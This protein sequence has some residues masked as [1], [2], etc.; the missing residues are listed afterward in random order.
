MLRVLDFV[1]L[2][3]PPFLSTPLI[4]MMRVS[5]VTALFRGSYTTDF[6]FDWNCCIP[7]WMY[8]YLLGVK[9]FKLY[10]GLMCPGLSHHWQMILILVL[11]AKLVLWVFNLVQG[12]CGLCF[13]LVTHSVSYPTCG[14]SRQLLPPL[15]SSDIYCF[16]K[17]TRTPVPFLICKYCLGR[18]LWW[19]DRPSTSQKN[20]IP[21]IW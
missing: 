3:L 14:Y 15:W 5:G 12:N 19:G 1:G 21:W 8:Q 13:D 10:L 16:P 4:D 17:K 2:V 7:L 18:Y 9:P 11:C 20:L 6:T